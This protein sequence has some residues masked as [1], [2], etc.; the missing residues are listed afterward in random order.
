MENIMQKLVY[1]KILFLSAL[2]IFSACSGSRQVISQPVGSYIKIDGISS[3]WQ[4][5]TN[6]KGENI[7]FGFS[8]DADNLYLIMITNDRNKIMNILLGGLKVW[9]DPG[10]SD[11]KIG[12]KYPDS[13]DP[14]DMMEFMKNRRMQDQLGIN[15]N[16]GGMPDNKE[17][18]PAM[19]LF[20]SQQKNLYIINDDDMVLKSFPIDGS[21]YQACLKV[22]KNYLCYELKIPFGNKPLLNYIMKNNNDKKITVNFVSGNLK[23][24]PDP[25]HKTDPIMGDDNH[26]SGPPMGGGPPGGGGRPPG[27]GGPPGGPGGGKQPN[28]PIDYS[29]V[30]IVNN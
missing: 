5:F 21:T 19:T 17:L 7:S 4:Q 29:F 15:K 23:S 24:L 8:N 30:V 11:D 22:D 2:L 16:P 12:I 26:P 6:M 10:N 3:E 9:V 14:A 27:G 20:L 28:V 18:D 1:L 25:M 13:P